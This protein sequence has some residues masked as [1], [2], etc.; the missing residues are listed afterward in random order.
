LKL[1]LRIAG[2]V[3]VVAIAIAWM[4][5]A[6][7]LSPYA[8]VA[9]IERAPTFRDAT[10]LAAV[11]RMLVAAAYLSHSFEYQ[12]NPSVSGPTSMDH[13]ASSSV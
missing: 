2:L 10:L 4:A 5:G 8:H 3:A 12:H 1:R 11:E 9:A 7:R 13:T 6:F